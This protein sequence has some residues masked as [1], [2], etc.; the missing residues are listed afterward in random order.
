[1]DIAGMDSETENS[2]HRF[3]LVIA[4]VA[5]FLIPQPAFAFK[6]FLDRARKIYDMYKPVSSCL[7]CHE[8]NEKKDEK[9]DKSNLNDYGHDMGNDPF[10]RPLV[11]V[12]EDHKFTAKEYETIETVLRS[13]DSV[14]SDKDGAT[15]LE[16]IELGT[17]PG[18]KNS[19]PG[20]DALK[21]YRDKKK[22]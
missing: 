22:K 21:K 15:N 17:F 14:D 4:I 3:A 18:N 1:M 11:D 9:P 5:L 10:M 7:L 16:E 6:Q 12:D 8:Y 13:L 20:S 19:V 2:M